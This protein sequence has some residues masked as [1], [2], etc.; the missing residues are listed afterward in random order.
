MK[1]WLDVEIDE[2]ND[3]FGEES[4]LNNDKVTCDFPSVRVV[5]IFYKRVNT[6][7]EP[8]YLIMKMQHYSRK[9]A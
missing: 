3:R 1:D 9:Q 6:D 2:N 7:K 4:E 8:Q 5:E